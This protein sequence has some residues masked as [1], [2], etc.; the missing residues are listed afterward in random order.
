MKRTFEFR[1]K[2]LAC[3]LRSPTCYRVRSTAFFFFF[4]WH[5]TFNLQFIKGISDSIDGTGA[6]IP[7]PNL[8]GAVLEKII[9]YCT[10]HKE[11]PVPPRA[12]DDYS[13]DNIS[14]WDLKFIAVDVPFLFDIVL[15]SESLDVLLFIYVT[16]LHRL[17][18][19]WT[20]L[21]YW[22][23]AVRLLQNW[24]LVRTYPRVFH[25]RLILSFRQD[26]WRN[27]GN[28]PN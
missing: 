18:I 11:T 24:S 26:T 1:E 7:L 9:E 15:V 27:R 25:C 20:L 8:N 14:E 4:F 22:I 19:I 21:L 12:E 6:P 13:V 23:L 3:L 28:I 5:T 16:T 2:L 10:Y 17:Q